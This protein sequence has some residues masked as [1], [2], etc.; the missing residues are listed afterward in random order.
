MNGIR[1]GVSHRVT[2]TPQP[3]D[4]ASGPSPREQ[5]SF[6]RTA[7]VIA[8][9][10][11]ASVRLSGPK[12]IAA[13]LM[14]RCNACRTELQAQGVKHPDFLGR[15]GNGSVF[16]NPERAEV[17]VQTGMDVCTVKSDGRVF[18]NGDLLERHQPRFLHLQRSLSEL[19]QKV[20]SG[21]LDR[22]ADAASAAPRSPWDR[23]SPAHANYVL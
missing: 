17:C 23:A 6:K 16:F 7:Q 12:A 21:G 8:G 15:D 3:R 4:S 13:A 14:A 20:A 10:A 5:V 2:E 19:G 1:S 9:H 18:M 11:T 22:S